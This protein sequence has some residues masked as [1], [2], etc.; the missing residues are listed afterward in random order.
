MTDGDGDRSKVD[1]ERDLYDSGETVGLTLDG[2][3]HSGRERT[4]TVRD[5]FDCRFCCIR[6]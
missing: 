5:D 6:G 3:E 2:G 4:E 1:L